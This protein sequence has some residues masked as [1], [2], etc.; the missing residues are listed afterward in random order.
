VLGPLT[1]PAAPI[2]VTRRLSCSRWEVVKR[3]RPGRGGRFSV[4]VPTH[5]REAVLRLRTTVGGGRRGSR[6]EPTFTLPRFVTPR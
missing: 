6:R 5:G 4:T 1:R 3:I 2:T